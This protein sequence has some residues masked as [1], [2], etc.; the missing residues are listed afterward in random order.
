MSARLRRSVRLGGGVARGSDG[1][2][3]KSL[4]REANACTAEGGGG[5]REAHIR[6]WN[7]LPAVADD[8]ASGGGNAFGVD[9][10]VVMSRLEDL[11][12]MVTKLY[13]GISGQLL[14][15]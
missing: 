3:A 13:P 10:R 4:I 9:E 15:V 5:C 7:G 11:G 6:D 14:K 12:S 8:S 1:P 2:G